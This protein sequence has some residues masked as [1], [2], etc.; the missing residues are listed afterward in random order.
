MVSN[1][2]TS[3][4]TVV[5]LAVLIGIAVFSG[6]G[7]DETTTDP[8]PGTGTAM[9]RNTSIIFLHH[10][11]GGVIWNGGVATAITTYNAVHNKEYSI[12]ELAYPD[13]PYPWAN[14][15]YDYWH[16]WVE[17]GGRATAEGVA[18]LASFTSSYNVVVFKHCFPVSGIGPDS[19]NPDISSESKTIENYKLQYEGLKTRLHEF[20][21][22]RF[23]IWTGAALVA[24]ASTAES[25]QRARRFFTWVKDEWDEPGDNIFVWDFYEL[26]TQG[27]N[28]LL[29]RL[30]AGSGNSH[31]NSTFARV[32]A[33]DFV[34]RL[35][36]VIEG[37]GETG[38]L[39]GE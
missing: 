6:C 4:G 10:S 8:G 29:D 12:T 31:P 21:N 11:T 1:R 22:N 30:S 34:Q 2:K 36:D 25:G 19:G 14:Y 3:S 20:P 32:V 7:D 18:T 37:R 39:T 9:P 23:V 24:S 33:P 13:A 15:P 16:L 5:F 27:D 28:F 38:S 17:D 35:I 26:E